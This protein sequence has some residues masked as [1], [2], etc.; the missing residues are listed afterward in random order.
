[1]K[2]LDASILDER[3]ENCDCE[4]EEGDEYWWVEVEEGDSNEYTMLCDNCY[5]GLLEAKGIPNIV[6]QGD[7]DSY[8][9]IY[10]RRR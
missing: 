9:R 6:Q 2:D 5:I 4:F 1:M 10:I 7:N 3:C 8:V